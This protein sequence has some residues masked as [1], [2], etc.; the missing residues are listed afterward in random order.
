[1]KYSLLIFFSFFFGC[2]VQL[3]GVSSLSSGSA[4]NPSV[5]VWDLNH[6]TAREFPNFTNFDLM[7]YY[8]NKIVNSE[9]ITVYLKLRIKSHIIFKIYLFAILTLHCCNGFYL[10]LMSW[11]LC[12][13]SVRT[14][15]CHDFSC[16]AAQAL[17]RAG[18][19]SFTSWALDFWLRNWGSQA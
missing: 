8:W 10:I 15:H 5:E 13:C 7:F 11:P 2:T 12:S 9:L 16:L 17:E 18:F 4:W 14:S 6:W 1:M 19:S 3:A